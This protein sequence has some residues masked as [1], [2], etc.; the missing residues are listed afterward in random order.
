MVARPSAS[1]REHLQIPTK[2]LVQFAQEWMVDCELKQH[3]KRTLDS[4]KMHLDKFFWFLKHRG[5][6]DVGSHELRQ[7]MQ[8]LC[9]GHEEPG[10]RWLNPQMTTPM[11]P[12][13]M[14]AYYR[15]LKAMFNWLVKDEAIQHNPFSKIPAPIHRSET[16]Q[17]LP[18]AD[19]EKLLA[20]ARASQNAKRD[21]ALVLF[22]IDTGVRCSELI[23]IRMCDL[24]QVSRT[25]R[26]LGKGQKYRTCYYSLPTSKAL[27]KYLR[28]REAT[29]HD[30]LFVCEVGPRK[31]KELRASGLFHIL[32][33]LAKAAGLDPKLCAPHALRRFYAVNMLRNGANAF[34]VQSL[35]GHEDMETTQLYVALATADIEQQAR[36]YSPVDRLAG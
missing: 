22:L 19:T 26:I 29:S 2:D 10:G 24:D 11:R 16:K 23:G 14:H 35:M 9:T 27:T 13:S 34:S 36:A 20:A 12:V 17:P 1:V 21:E 5:I 4:R 3:T 32:E 15:V 28:K 18:L 30:H 31:G 8:Y 7:F 33:R 25:C 6:T